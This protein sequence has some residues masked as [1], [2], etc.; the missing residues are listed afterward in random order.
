[1][2]AVRNQGLR[3]R[4][5]ADDHLREGEQEIEGRRNPGRA[6]PLAIAL[7]V[8]RVGA[9]AAFFVSHVSIWLILPSPRL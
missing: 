3:M 9:A 4:K 1:M 2:Q 6:L 8:D 5:P 7:Q